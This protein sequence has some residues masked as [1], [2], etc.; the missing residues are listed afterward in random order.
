MPCLL[1]N[2]TSVEPP[3]AWAVRWLSIRDLHALGA[4][5]RRSAAA[6]SIVRMAG[7]VA[8]RAPVLGDVPVQDCGMRLLGS[9]QLQVLQVLGLEIR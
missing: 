2:R 6:L 9:Q 3:H 7:K 4:E 5:D 8:S 1:L